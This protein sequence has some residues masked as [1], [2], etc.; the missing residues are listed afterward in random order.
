MTE[1]LDQAR[2]YLPGVL[3]AIGL[4]ALGWLAARVL[5]RGTTRLVD[6]FAPQ[7][8][9][10]AT[11]LAVTPLGVERRVAEIVGSLVFW[12]VFVLFVGAA[13]EAM[14]LPV[15]ANWLAS[16][17]GLLPKLLVAGLIVLAGVLFGA[18]ARDAVVTA[19]RAGGL[20]RGDLLGRA[21]QFA[22]VTAAIVTG[23]EQVGIDSQ[24]FTAVLTVTLGAALGGA[25]LAFA[26][27][28]RT[29]VGNIIAM[30]Y[31]RQSYKVGQTVRVHEARGRIRELTSTA[32]VLETSDSL[33]RVPGRL[34]SEHV[35]EVVTSGE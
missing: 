23:V 8:E 34:F 10:R 32:V 12:V 11:Q 26:F 9:R 6:R 25:A 2:L 28:A 19:S 30:H 13:A 15:L 21:A 27:G 29:D 20:A 7:L 3:A 18:I 24:F 5:S 35:S 4:L 22:I 17:A 31:V 33:L 14:G 1:F 16:V